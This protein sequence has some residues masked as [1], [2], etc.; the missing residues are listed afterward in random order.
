VADETNMSAADV[1]RRSFDAIAKGD[2]DTLESLLTPSSVDDFVAV[3]EFRGPASIR[4][5]FEETFRAFPDFE[6]KVD[7]IV[8][9]ETTAVVQ[10]RARGTF[11]GGVFQGIEPTGKRVEIRGVDVMD[12]S[13]GHIQHN[14]IYYDGA[15]LA[16]QIG[17]L[18]K[19]GSGADK[20][21]MSA[22]NAVTKLRNRVTI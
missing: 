8:A 1:A 17:M 12:I 13:G 11:T 14:T 9:D 20:A 21:V 6:M 4:R 2:L 5:F 15:S 22:F 19:Q 16:R 10:W 18:P 7:R 3:G